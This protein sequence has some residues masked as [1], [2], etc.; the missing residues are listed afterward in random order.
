MARKSL[1]VRST[2]MCWKL[3]GN[4]LKIE[5]N[6]LKSLSSIASNTN[7]NAVVYEKI[8]SI[9]LFWLNKAAYIHNTSSL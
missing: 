9:I 8:K 4:L 3:Y 2:Q 7:V 6:F 1:R 5:N